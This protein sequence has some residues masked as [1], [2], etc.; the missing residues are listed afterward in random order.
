MAAVYSWGVPNESVFQIIWISSTAAVKS[1]SVAPT[2]RAN[3]SPRS[4]QGKTTW[5]HV[6]L[7]GGHF[8]TA[9]LP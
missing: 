9:Y 6:R 2:L 5:T 1:G 8:F 7:S 4:L 3:E